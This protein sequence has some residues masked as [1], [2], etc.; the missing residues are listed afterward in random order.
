MSDFVT[1]WCPT[2]PLGTHYTWR[3]HVAQYGD[4]YQQR[5]LDG[6]NA[7]D[8]TYSVS[9]VNRTQSVIN[10]MI[11]YLLTQKSKSFNFKHPVTGVIIPVFCN[12][13]T[14][15][16]TLVNWNAAGQRTVYGDFTADFLKAN[17]VSG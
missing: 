6:I 3:M 4:G 15:D 13:W 12:E 9:F 7:M 8:T 17:G 16:W 2:P 1:G 11:A 10:D 14:V 5:Q